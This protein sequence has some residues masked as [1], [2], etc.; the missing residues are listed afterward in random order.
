MYITSFYSYS[1]SCGALPPCEGLETDDPYVTCCPV[2][3]TPFDR[4]VG[5]L[6]TAGFGIA[7]ISLRKRK[8]INSNL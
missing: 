7:I 2:V 8:I 5:L 6:I 3:T 4:E 1:Q